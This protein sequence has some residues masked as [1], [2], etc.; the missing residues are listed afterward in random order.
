MYYSGLDLGKMKDCTALAV[1]E[2]TPQREFK[3]VYWERA[4]L[5]T[6]YTRGF[7]G[8]RS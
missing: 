3:V 4:P 2:R 1:V 8:W 7:N 6:P 5:G